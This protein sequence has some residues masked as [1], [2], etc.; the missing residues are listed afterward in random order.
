MVARCDLNPGSHW[1]PNLTASCWF[2]ICR[3]LIRIMGSEI[4]TEAS[5][6]DKRG[7][8]QPKR[9]QACHKPTSIY[10]RCLSHCETL[11]PL[12]ICL[13]APSGHFR[14]TFEC[15]WT[16]VSVL[17]LCNHHHPVDSQSGIP[18]PLKRKWF[19]QL[20]LEVPPVASQPI[21]EIC[22]SSRQHLEMEM[23]GTVG[24]GSEISIKG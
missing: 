9:S 22:N 5:D 23:G 19:P 7:T 13:V 18:S 15:H 20:A 1:C 14:P 24:S 3:F 21:V 16:L 17:I 8:D 2:L 6:S 10:D 12:Q 11:Q 4:S